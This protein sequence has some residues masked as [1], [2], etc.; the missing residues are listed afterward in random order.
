MPEMNSRPRL[1]AL[2]AWAAGAGVDG[3]LLAFEE[4]IENGDGPDWSRCDWIASAFHMLFGTVERAV[5]AKAGP[6]L[7]YSF[8]LPETIAPL[9]ERAWVNRVF[10]F[11]RAWAAREAGVAEDELFGPRPSAE[12]LL[13]HDVDALRLTPEIRLKQT[14]FQLLNMGRSL[15]RRR[16][17][18]AAARLGD[19]ARY[20]LSAGNLQTLSRVRDMERAAGIR[21]A[22]HFYAGPPGIERG[23]LRR[24]L[25]DPAYDVA[26][27]ETRRELSAF[28]E[29]GWTVGL[30]QSFDAWREAGPMIAERERLEAVVGVP[31]IHC[32]QHWL[33]FS[34]R[35]TWRAQT[36][37]GLRRDAT[38][39]FNDRPGF[40]A[41]HALSIHPWD[42][43]EGAALAV[44]A[45]PMILMDSHFHDYAGGPASE[46]VGEAIRPWLQEVRLVGGTAT[47]NWH[48]HTITDVYGWG[49]G[50]EAL[51]DQLTGD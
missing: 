4:T 37:A 7:S 3:R 22:L 28:V 43:E 16:V 51:L 34:W 12:I 5:E 18:E 33:R 31:I 10:L 13:T 49:G 11:L 35:E 48:T 26:G 46:P 19:A 36:R 15:A 45:L 42:P 2:P 24:I 40:R 27:A 30:H 41:G 1:V 38:L 14:A 25:I 23:S 21:S 50:Y 8:R 17:G 29:G 6:T 44:E 9:H 20:A 32:R 39:G 47:V